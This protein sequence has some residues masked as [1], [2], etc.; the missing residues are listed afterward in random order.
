MYN[1]IFRDTYHNLIV[2]EDCYVAFKN[3]EFFQLI[4]DLD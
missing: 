4:L 2:T 1:R 3:V